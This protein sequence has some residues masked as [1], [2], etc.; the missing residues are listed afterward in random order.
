MKE[1]TKKEGIVRSLLSGKEKAD[2]EAMIDMMMKALKT[3]HSAIAVSD[4]TDPEALAKQRAGHERLSKLVTPAVGINY[5]KDEVEGIPVMWAVPGFAHRERPVILYCHGGG[6]TGGGLGYAGILAGKMALHTGLPV[7]TFE[8]RLAPENPYPAPIEDAMNMWDHLMY[9]GY[10]ANDVIVAGDSAGGNMALEIV[11]KLKSQK[12]MMPAGLV[13][14]SPWTDMTATLPSYEKY[15]DTDPMLTYE[16]VCGSR[17]AYAGSETDYT[18]P[19]LSPLYGDLDDMPPTLI[20]VG[21]NEILRNDSEYLHKKLQKN[22]CLSRL[23]VYSGGWHVFQVLPTVKA[24]RAMD[25]VNDF[26]REAKL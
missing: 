2:N 9:L 10:G 8:Y 20:E 26:I 23:H 17:S 15:K 18:D 25:D 19:F 6:Y 22:G 16:Y 24:A 14:F 5:T 7:F 4:V 3:V 13:L 12:R 11:L 21:S 1:E